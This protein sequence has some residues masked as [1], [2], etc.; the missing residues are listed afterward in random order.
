MKRKSFTLIEILVALIV[1]SILASLSVATY[2]KTV[3]ANNERI[4]A[5]NLKVLQAAIDIYTVE[6]DILPAA[7]SQLN[8]RYIY[9][10]SSRVIGE[11]KESFLSVAF[12]KIFSTEQALAVETQGQLF[13]RR[14]L[15]GKKKIFHD[16]AAGTYTEDPADC[17]NIS[18]GSYQFNFTANKTLDSTGTKLDKNSIFALVFDPS[19]RHRG[20]YSASGAA[21]YKIGIT[22]G[23]RVGKVNG[24]DT[25]S[26]IQ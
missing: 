2:Q 10:A 14:Y 13:K 8:P 26:Y 12:R 1:L 24:A 3:D 21:T 16:P 25:S 4:C 17:G 18:C 22:P 5:E 20:K 19:D 11:R 15:G 7:L 23:G 6:N 9:L